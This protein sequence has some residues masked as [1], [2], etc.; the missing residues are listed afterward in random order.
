MRY[1][2]ILEGLAVLFIVLVI[3]LQMS[4]SN[5][6]K[7]SVEPGFYEEEFYLEIKGGHGNIYYTLD[8]SMPDES[9]YLYTEPI[10]IRDVSTDENVYSILPDCYLEFHPTC[11]ENGFFEDT[12]YTLP[13]KPVDKAMTIRAVCIDEEGNKSECLTGSYYVDYSEKL[14]YDN[15]YIMSIV[16]DPVNLFDYE[17]GIYVTGA[18]FDEYMNSLENMD[19][20]KYYNSPGNFTEKGKAQRRDANVTVWNTKRNLVFQNDCK[21]SIQ[22]ASSRGWLPRSLNIYKNNP[23]KQSFHHEKLG[24]SYESDGFTLW[25]GASDNYTKLNDALLNKLVYDLGLSARNYI[26]CAMFLDGEFWGVYYITERYEEA[27]FERKYGI[28]GK[29][30]VMIKNGQVEIGK[31]SDREYYEHLWNSYKDF[32]LSDEDSFEKLCSIIDMDSCLNYYAVELYICNVD[33]PNNYAIWKS[34]E[35]GK[36]YH[37]GRWRWIIFDVNKSMSYRD[38]EKNRLVEVLEKDPLLAHLIENEKFYTLL[39]KKLIF[40]ADNYFHPDMIS[41][42]IDAYELNMENAIRKEY[43]RFYGENLNIE[44]FY[45]MCEQVRT[46]YQERYDYIKGMYGD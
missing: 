39:K 13:E 8:S 20:F 22:G 29:D 3:S 25:G 27:F 37:D 6:L 26:P 36:G 17:E 23:K 9:S 16:S 18:V 44:R 4:N 5:D 11:I 12:R 35:S 46:F 24:L 38:G 28:S 32:S 1:I 41:E 21:I 19:T 40:L 30:T 43:E 31:D 34:R 14:G 15:L 45:T 33:W 7:F 42:Y 2:H 10:L